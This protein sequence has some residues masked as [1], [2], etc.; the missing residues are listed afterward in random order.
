MKIG[1][2]G[3]TYQQL[4]LPFDAQRTINFYPIMDQTGKEVASL[5]GTPGLLL[6]GNLGNSVMRGEFLSATGRAFAICG[7]NFYEVAA[8][9]IGTLLGSLRQS[10]GNVF[11]EENPVQIAICDLINL[12]VMDYATNTFAQVNGGLE[13]VTN[14]N[15]TV[16]TGWTLGSGWTISGG[17]AKAS[18]A[19]AN[20][21]QTSAIALISGQSYVVSYSVD[22]ISFV[23]N[24]TFATD[25]GWIKGSGWTIGGGAAN[26]TAATSGLSQT[27]PEDLVNTRTYSV[28]YTVLNY[29]SGSVAVSLGG[30]TAGTSI[31][32]NGT[33]TQ[34]ITAGSTQ[35]VTFQGTA[36]NGSIDNVSISVVGAGTVVASVG[37]TQGVIRTVSGQYTETIVAGASQTIAFVG[38]GF[39]GTI[40]SVTI[41]DQS[42][43]LPASVG[44]LTYI[45]SFF[46]VTENKTGRFWK[47]APN[48]GL[49]WN[50][51]D[52]ANAES[53]PDNLFC[54]KA[55]VGQ[56]WLLG[57]KT[58]EIWTN[59][60][61]SLFP[62]AKI[63]GGKMTQGILASCTALEL[64]NTLFWVGQNDFGKG[65][66]YRAVGFIPKRISTEP[67]EIIISKATDP[68]NIRAWSYQQDGHLFYVLTGGGLPTSPCYDITTDM[69]HERA[70]LNSQGA[71]EQ[72]LGCCY[73]NAF[74]KH[75]VG[76]RK[77]GN[78]YSMEDD[79]YTDNG[80]TLVAERIYTHISDEDKLIRYN[81]LVI[82]VESGVGLQSGQ[83]SQPVIELQ[84]SKDGARTWSD[85]FT[86]PIGASG[87]YSEK[88]AFKRL[89]VAP[90]MTFKIRISDPVKRSITGSYL[91]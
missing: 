32:A 28:T 73:M 4:S 74:G 15:F 51:L 79:I 62:F 20:L 8:N 9:G 84:L 40:S 7:S 70:F 47:S 60:G 31:S 30:G 68:T 44:S 75:L 57:G 90:Q 10:N 72:H 56:L 14:G 63:S 13:Y 2:V 86:K 39:T 71:Y 81:K 83:G 33:V 12:Y 59:T 64:D 38:F 58:T 80:S 24:G 78:I 26:A 45:D 67:I 52:F 66:V 17:F 37:G 50:A 48:N 89:G 61:N 16:G 91:Q 46:I 65:I 22:V 87:E 25:T 6:F 29:V 36:F 11:I 5:F 3:A 1:L 54:A 85:R 35:S 27:A 19:S 34:T 49:S 21:S 76:D 69:W 18:S 42:F 88:I 41:N 77:T 43:G 53:S 23:T 55:A 82:G